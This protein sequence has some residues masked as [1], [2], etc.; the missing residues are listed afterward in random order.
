M[1][2]GAKEEEGEKTG[3]GVLLGWQ[4]ENIARMDTRT[5]RERMNEIRLSRPVIGGADVGIEWSGGARGSVARIHCLYGSIRCSRYLR[6]RREQ[7]HVRIKPRKCLPSTNYRNSPLQT[8]DREYL[9]QMLT[10]T[11][12]RDR[13]CDASNSSG[14]ADGKDG[15]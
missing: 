10:G 13:A 3:A 8:I 11:K 5:E 14:G 4:Y 7:Q 15:E 12:R 2:R 9:L 1:R 6:S